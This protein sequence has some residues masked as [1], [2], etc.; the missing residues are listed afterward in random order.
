M[1]SAIQYTGNGV[2][3]DFV[4]SFPFLLQAHV[5]VS[6]NGTPTAIAS[7]PT[8]STIRLAAAPVSG[9]AVLIRRNSS[10]L[11]RVVDFVDGSP[12][13]GSLLDQDSN[14][15]LYIAQEALDQNTTAA[16]FTAD[17]NGSRVRN[18]A[19]PVLNTDGATKGW[20]Q[21]Y[22]SSI[23]TSG[24]NLL[25]LDNP[26]T[27]INSFAQKITLG[28]ADIDPSTIAALDLLSVKKGVFVDYTTNH[29]TAI[30]Y[31]FAT[32]VRRASGY[33]LV[34]GAQINSWGEGTFNGEQFGMAVETIKKPTATGGMVGFE[35]SCANFNGT[36]AREHILGADLVF[37]TH[38]DGGTTGGDTVG[39]ANNL[40][41]ANSWAL[42]ISA[43][44][45]PD[46]GA[47]YSGW[48]RGV[49]FVAGGLDR[50]KLLAYDNAK[51]YSP[52]D[53]VTSGGK[54]YHCKE[55]TTGNAPVAGGTPFWA[56]LGAGTEKNAI[57]ID[58]SSMDALTAGRV[59][60]AIK[61][62]GQMPIMWDT[63]ELI[64][65][66]FD[67]VTGRWAVK[68]GGV[69]AAGIDAATGDVCV[70][71]LR[72]VLATRSSVSAHRNTVTTVVIGGWTQIIPQTKE[73]DDRNEYSTSTGR[74]TPNTA[75]DY[76]VVWQVQTEGA[77]PAG[78]R[79]YAGVFL[80]GSVYKTGE[81]TS[82]GSNTTALCSTIVRMNGTGD[83]IDFRALSMYGPG[84]GITGEPTATFL[85]ISKVQ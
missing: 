66:A 13:T 10:R 63:E 11:T 60:A 1:Y 45:R 83:F 17:A 3:T 35:S 25:P 16:F 8:A 52:G 70:R 14:Q 41:N 40:Y 49:R 77:E 9:A 51:P 22:V 58:F 57:G 44:L 26:W 75:G 24:L 79:L 85:Q 81:A 29:A 2:Q 56:D 42:Q 53:Y 30:G 61:L 65:T 48:N 19:D 73:R 62:R 50:A 27:G 64:T 72:R 6:V 20:V 33:P 38:S 28:T 59:D 82:S 67:P 84:V 31:G 34:V 21:A 78:N 15:L 76:H 46:G 43:Q 23:T 12:V 4:V 71:G 47:T 5:E 36:T 37:K 18:V 69:E 54:R 39:T 74:F 55:F 32:N 7:W 68:N 80:N